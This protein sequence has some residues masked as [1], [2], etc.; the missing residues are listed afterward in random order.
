MFNMNP[1]DTMEVLIY[2]QTQSSQ[3]DKTVSLG[4][5]KGVPRDR[6]YE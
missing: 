5:P 2:L 3:P 1:L 6:Q 4:T